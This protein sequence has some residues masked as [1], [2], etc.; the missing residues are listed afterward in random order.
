MSQVDGLA[1]LAGGTRPNHDT[2]VIVMTA[3]RA[4]SRAWTR[5]RQGAFDYLRSPSPPPPAGLDRPRVHT[6]AGRPRDPRANRNARPGAGQSDKLTLLAPR[7]RSAGRSSWPEGVRPML[8]SHHGESGSARSMIA[9]F[10][11][12]HSRRSSRPFIAIT[13]RRCREGLL[14]SEN[15]ATVRGPSRRVR[16]KPVCSKPPTAGHAVSRRAGRDAQAGSRRSCCASFRTAWY[17][18]SAARRLMRWST[19]AHRRDQ[20]RSRGD[21]Q[22]GGHAEDLYYRCGSVRSTCGAA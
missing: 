19:C 16:D 4:S 3:T 12:H 6:L 15:V 13:A 11:H 1:L 18:G 22:G 20:R 10:I 5:L 14:E 9:Q 7:R 8:P 17:V 2:I 21:R